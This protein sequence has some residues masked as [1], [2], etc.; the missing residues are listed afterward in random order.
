MWA[1]FDALYGG[2]V[3]EPIWPATDARNTSVPRPR[4]AIPGATAWA[5]FT[6]PRT[7]TRSTRGQSAGVRFVKGNPNLPEPTAAAWTR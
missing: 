1:A 4:S 5:T 6:I 7:F 2:S 3:C